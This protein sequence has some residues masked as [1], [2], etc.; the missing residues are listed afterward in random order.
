M[1]N[2]YKRNKKLDKKTT[3]N[4][5]IDNLE[6]HGNLLYR[7]PDDDAIEVDNVYHKPNVP[8]ECAGDC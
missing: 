6:I 2:K 1:N 7:K 3:L 4:R 8:G 5:R